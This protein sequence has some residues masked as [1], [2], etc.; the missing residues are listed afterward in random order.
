MHLWYK[1]VAT[2][3]GVAIAIYRSRTPL[4]MVLYQFLS[5]TW[6][7][8]G[9]AIGICILEE[10]GKSD[11]ELT[12]VFLR[13]FLITTPVLRLKVR[14]NGKNRNNGEVKGKK[15]RCEAILKD[16]RIIRVTR[17]M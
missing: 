4:C 9:I 14:Q 13:N 1:I 2:E 3:K 8:V 16:A 12:D 6:F 11:L 15:N 17:Q 5:L 7:N 10:S